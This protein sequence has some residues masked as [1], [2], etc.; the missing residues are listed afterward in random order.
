[1]RRRNNAIKFRFGTWKQEVKTAAKN[2]ESV[3]N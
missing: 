2:K 3:Q 1:M